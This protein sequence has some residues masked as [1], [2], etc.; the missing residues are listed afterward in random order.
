MSEA[1][2]TSRKDFEAVFPSLVEDLSEAAKQYNI[3][4]PALQWFQRVHSPP[5]MTNWLVLKQVAVSECKYA[6]RQAQSR[7]LSA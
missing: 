2:K 4:K 6:W 3:P 5:N 7:P 1:S